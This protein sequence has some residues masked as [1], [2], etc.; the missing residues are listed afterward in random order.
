M[1]K[2]HALKRQNITDLIREKLFLT[3]FADEEK[4]ESTKEETDKEETKEEQKEESSINYEDLISKARKEEKEK[5]Y[6]KISTLE[7]EKKDLI[8]KHNSSLLTIGELQSKIEKL[9]KKEETLDTTKEED[10]DLKALKI[11]LE[12]KELELK[13]LLETTESVEDVEERVRKAISEEYEVKLYREQK[14]R[15][16]GDNIIPELVMGT[17]KEEI[18]KSI[19]I[20]QNR[21]ND[22]VKRTVSGVK[23]PPANTSTSK[24]NSTEYKLED[25]A[26]LD[27]RSEEYRELR[28]K[29]GLK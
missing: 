8:E 25:L 7:K 28:K 21:F 11:A 3:V 15:Q 5:L 13:T 17:T 29:L 10:K 2:N 9:S 16:V 6:P 14:L 27:P 24:F 20:S 23:I 19:E 4:E 18:D 26:R 1:R 12:E 22:I